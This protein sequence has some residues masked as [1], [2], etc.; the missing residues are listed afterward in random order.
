MK[1]T[2]RC[3]VRVRV[4]LNREWNDFRYYPIGYYY[5]TDEDFDMGNRTIVTSRDLPHHGTMVE[6]EHFFGNIEFRVVGSNRCVASTEYN[7]I[8]QS[9]IDEYI[10]KNGKIGFVELEIADYVRV[11]SPTNYETDLIICNGEVIAEI[12]REQGY[13]LT[14]STTPKLDQNNLVVV[15]SIEYINE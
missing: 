5:K 12:D 6:S 8:S 2:I 9:F 7:Q 13:D 15:A 14:S 10:A 4:A 3:E 11:E 1:R